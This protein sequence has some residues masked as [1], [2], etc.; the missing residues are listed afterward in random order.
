M[1]HLTRWRL[2]VLP[3]LVGLMA[4]SACG[5]QWL[6]AYFMADRHPKKEV[7]AEYELTAEK[8]VIIP[9][10][11]TEI[12]FSDSTLTVEIAFNMVNEIVRNLGPKKVMTIVHPAEVN[13]WQESTL[14]W[15]N[16]SLTDMAKAFGADTV[17]YVELEHYS[18]VEEH[19]ANLYRGRVSARIQVARLSA[20]QNPVYTT[21]V[22]TVYPEDMPVGMTGTTEGAVR[23][24]TNIVFANQVIQKF[25]N[26]QVEIRGAAQ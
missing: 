19:S 14:E 10:A 6:T 22:E 26:H 20:P 23:R 17:L 13:R 21:T 4:L 7:K 15:P 5:C 24:V 9:Y 8:L 25:Y 18:T 16:M 3:V 11:G 2:F 1:R 12:L